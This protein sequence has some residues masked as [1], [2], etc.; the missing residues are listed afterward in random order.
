MVGGDIDTAGGDSYTAGPD[1]GAAE[2]DTGIAGGDNE[3]VDV[4]EFGSIRIAFLG[5]N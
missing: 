3:T 1:T 4:D 5:P 2:C